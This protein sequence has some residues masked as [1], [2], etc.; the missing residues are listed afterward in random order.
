MEQPPF[1]AAP[2]DW[3]RVEL[4]GGFG[5]R[6]SVV[7]GRQLMGLCRRV[8]IKYLGAVSALDFFKVHVENYVGAAAFLRCWSALD[9]L[10]TLLRLEV[11]LVGA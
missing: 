9:F 11:L 5:S 1:R 4:S 2:F 7:S 6:R 10:K 3:L 8:G